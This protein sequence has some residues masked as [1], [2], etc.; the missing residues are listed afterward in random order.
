MICQPPCRRSGRLLLAACLPG[1]LSIA[2]QAQTAETPPPALSFEQAATLQSQASARQ[3]GA[4][5]GVAAA[6]A[7]RDAVS[8]LH[9]PQVSLDV[10][11]LRY[12]K[13]ITVPLN[14]VKQGVQNN[15]NSALT[16]A[17][18]QVRDQ[19][20]EAAGS[21]A[22]QVAAQVSSLLPGIVAPIPDSLS[23]SFR[24]NNFRPTVSA[25][26]PIY[27]GGAISAA[28]GAAAAKLRE[29]TAAEGIATDADRVSLV[30]AYFGQAL[31][32]QVLATRRD[33]LAGM[34]RHLRDA[35]LLEAHGV[36]P[37][38]RR[39]EVQVARDA[40]ERAVLRAEGDYRT[41]QLSLA[42]QLQSGAVRTATPLF[43]NQAP[44]GPED[45][46][47]LASA[48][49]PQIRAAS[50]AQD[51]AGSATKLVRA[52]YLPKIYAFGTY[53]LARHD[54]VPTLPDWAVGVGVHMTLLSGTDRA[55]EMR[56]AHAREA[57]SAAARDQ[58]ERDVKLT[59]ERAWTLTDTTRREYLSE[60]S[61]LT[62]A[63][64]NLRTQE[65]AFRE[66]EG[67]TASVID[68]QNL[69][70]DALVQRAA[71]AYEYDL[72]LIALLTTSGQA[73]RFES[74]RTRADALD[75]PTDDDET[76]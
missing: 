9:R 16:Q 61:S 75:A 41:A 14:G 64:E 50:G 8:T 30:Q 39:L 54:E 72:A 19:Y 52:Q 37:R 33:T 10:Q 55:A 65:A 13:T 46:F 23:G 26:L 35:T 11:E 48:A 38:A 20:G 36:L 31:A 22:D 5:A 66:G 34:D 59:V 58:A 42:S 70:G 69:L 18:G 27:M 17:A 68:A 57:Q 45:G 71:T 32:A 73:E 43:V 1:L 56:A 21:V 7:D 60:A 67:T 25:V 51:A 24:Q 29:A 15:V 63:R 47:V 74:L 53:N 3:R 62:A 4:A 40:A 2:A 49:N 28:Q 12:Q 44:V 76:P 6:K